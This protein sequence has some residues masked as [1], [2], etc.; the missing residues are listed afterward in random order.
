MPHMEYV[1]IC[2]AWDPNL[3]KKILAVHKFD[4]M[5]CSKQWGVR[6]SSLAEAMHVL[7]HP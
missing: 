2:V 4:L 1:Y 6:Y 5:V 7:R 3:A